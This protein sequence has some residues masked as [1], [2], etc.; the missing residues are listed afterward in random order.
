MKSRSSEQY[1]RVEEFKPCASHNLAGIARFG[2]DDRVLLAHSKWEQSDWSSETNHLVRPDST[3]T[4][5]AV[6]PRIPGELKALRAGPT[7]RPGIGC[8]LHA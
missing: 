5:R 3:R 8:A 7:N 6:M 2:D 4:G 1:R